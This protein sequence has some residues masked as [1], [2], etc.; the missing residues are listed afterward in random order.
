MVAPQ[1]SPAKVGH[2]AGLDPWW[3]PQDVV[4][5][6]GGG[7]KT[8]MQLARRVMELK[9]W[10][11]RKERTAQRAVEEC[12]RQGYLKHVAGSRLLVLGGKLQPRTQP[13]RTGRAE[14]PAGEEG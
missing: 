9:G 7:Q 11:E 6:L 2:S 1:E 3:E 10:N 14:Y 12:E 5:A 13:A 8:Q 4:D